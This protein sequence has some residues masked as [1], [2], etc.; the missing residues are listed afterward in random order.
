[1]LAF[2]SCSTKTVARP[3]AEESMRSG[4][5]LFKKKK[6]DRAIEQFESALMESE[7]PEMASK[8][9]LFLADSYFFSKRYA[10]SIPAYE[11]FLSIYGETS[12]ADT[13]MLRLGLSHYAMMTTMD[14]DMAAV[15]GALKAFTELRDKSP[16]YAREFELNKKIVELRSILA[17]REL[18]VAKFYFRTKQ[19]P[20]AEGRLRYIIEN[21]ED[22][23]AFEEALYMYANWLKGMKGSE[24]EAVKYYNRLIKERPNS[25]YVVDVARELTS[26]LAKITVEME[27]KGAK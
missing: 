5:E 16:S 2:A 11:Q 12:D 7:T 6:Y 17:G 27:K 23:P 4:M 24:A 21:Y 26:L 3:S 19:A 10:E 22:T 25:K 15:E 13:A 20:A 18:Y 8:A 9:Q 14:R 1:M